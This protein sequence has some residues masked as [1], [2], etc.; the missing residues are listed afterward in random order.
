MLK[1]LGVKMEM[2]KCPKCKEELGYLKYW[3]KVDRSF[4]FELVE[5]TDMPDYSDEEIE[6]TEAQDLE[7]VCP[8]C[9]EQICT[10]EEKAIR[11]LKNEPDIKQVIDKV[12]EMKN[13]T[14]IKKN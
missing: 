2:P 12:K 5:K 10:D 7:W 6:D 1:R 14:E 8:Y 11:F 4:R 13:E 3:E 9:M